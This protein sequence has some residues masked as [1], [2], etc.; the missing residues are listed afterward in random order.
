IDRGRTEPGVLVPQALQA[1]L[2]PFPR[3]DVRH[4]RTIDE[5]IEDLKNV[6]LNDVKTFHQE[7]YG[8]SQGELI[9]VG[10]FDAATLEKAAAGLLASW[11]SSKSYERIVTNFTNVRTINS[12]IETPDKENAQFSAG[13]S[14]PMRD[15]DPDYPA[16]VMANF[17]FGGGI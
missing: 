8:A 14:L 2:S 9:V 11:K 7:F 17:I 6:T 16:M 13:L 5:E 12:K 15:T 10:K 1:N 4:V 3:S